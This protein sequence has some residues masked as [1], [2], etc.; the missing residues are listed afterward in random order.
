MLPPLRE[1]SCDIPLLA[2]H[3]LRQYGGESHALDV[4]AIKRLFAVLLYGLAI[5]MAWRGL[6]A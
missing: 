3:F 6:S 5:Y 1:R 4:G 2:A